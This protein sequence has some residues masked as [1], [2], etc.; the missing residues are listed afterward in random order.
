VPNAKI[1]FA[2][3]PVGESHLE[4]IEAQNYRFRRLF[5]KDYKMFSAE[6]DMHMMDVLQESFNLF[7]RTKD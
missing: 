2:L 3:C 6:I 1:A 7:K 4:L 5:R